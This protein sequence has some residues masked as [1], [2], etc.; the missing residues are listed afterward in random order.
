LFLRKKNNTENEGGARET[1][2][3]FK[4]ANPDLKKG[5]LG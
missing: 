4:K 3:Q 5:I 2:K 1:Y